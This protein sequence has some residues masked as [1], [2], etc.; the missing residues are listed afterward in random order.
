MEFDNSWMKFL[1]FHV[2][3]TTTIM[4]LDEHIHE[5][6]REYFYQMKNFEILSLIKQ[7]PPNHRAYKSLC[8]KY[9]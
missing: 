5:I 4:V 1:K 9:I 7:H 3:I 2:Q 8:I 6:F